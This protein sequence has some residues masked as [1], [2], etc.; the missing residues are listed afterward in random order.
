MKSKLLTLNT[1]NILDIITTYIALSLGLYET[2]VLMEI[3]IDK[4]PL[5]HISLKLI[6]VALLSLILYKAK[7]KVGFNICIIA[8]ILIVISNIIMIGSMILC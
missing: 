3:L 1:L 4:N 7:S 8:F 6:G 2:N 5:L